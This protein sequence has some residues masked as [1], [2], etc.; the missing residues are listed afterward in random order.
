MALTGD[1]LAGCDPTVMVVEVVT[2]VTADAALADVVVVVG[3]A[4][5]TE[6]TANVA[7]LPGNFDM[8]DGEPEPVIDF[9]FFCFV[10]FKNKKI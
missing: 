1:R 8:T 5:A 7:A 6:L 10:F 9:L 4:V 3:D 2:V